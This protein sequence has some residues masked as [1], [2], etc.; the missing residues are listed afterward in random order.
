[1]VVAAQRA[2]G[3]GAMA[4]IT[5]RSIQARW[6]LRERK[7][8]PSK[9][10]SMP[11]TR[12]AS[13]RSM[14]I[15]IPRSLPNHSQSSAYGKSNFT[16]HSEP[17]TAGI[18]RTYVPG[19]KAHAVIRRSISS[20]AASL[21]VTIFFKDESTAVS[22]RRCNGIEENAR[23]HARVARFAV[24]VLAEDLLDAAK[25]YEDDDVDPILRDAAMRILRNRATAGALELSG[26]NFLSR[27]V[28]KREEHRHISCSIVRQRGHAHLCSGRTRAAMVEFTNSHCCPKRVT[29]I[30]S[31]GI[32]LVIGSFS[33]TLPFNYFTIGILSPS[34]LGELWSDMQTAQDLSARIAETTTAPH[35]VQV[36]R[37][38]FQ[39]D[40]RNRSTIGTC[41]YPCYEDGH[42][43]K[44]A[45]KD[46]FICGN[47]DADNVMDK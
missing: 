25:G 27:S 36:T 12:S 3:V 31:C 28:H 35:I 34:S 44:H 29:R 11:I 40:H 8:S 7:S 22:V 43:S 33:K 1:M 38:L 42:E 16:S 18:S 39:N 6:L 21:S 45:R 32:S 14:T 2:C 37:Y 9:S 10:I 13:L 17:A 23:V 30:Y 15:E 4:L 5:C 41:P 24:D 20:A 47:E 26:S 46:R 19:S